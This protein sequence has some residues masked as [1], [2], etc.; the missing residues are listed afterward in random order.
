MAVGDRIIRQLETGWHT[1][2]LKEFAQQ[3]KW[4]IFLNSQTRLKEVPAGTHSLHV[5]VLSWPGH[6]NLPDLENPYAVEVISFEMREG[7]NGPICVGYGGASDCLVF[8][9]PNPHVTV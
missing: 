7:P 8:W 6:I 1:Q 4:Y 2:T 5:P 9:K 3:A